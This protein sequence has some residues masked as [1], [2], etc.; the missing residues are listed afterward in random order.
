MAAANCAILCHVTTWL[1]YNISEPSGRQLIPD[2]NVC[3]ICTVKDLWGWDASYAITWDLAY[4]SKHLHAQKTGAIVRGL[5][6]WALRLNS[7]IWLK[8]V[9][10]L[11]RSHHTNNPVHYMRKCPC[12]GKNRPASTSLSNSIIFIMRKILR[13][14]ELTTNW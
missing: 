10:F 13:V 5:L 9:F 4:L 12:K 11:A 3:F 6:Q 8:I 1:G 14:L 7:L 2:G